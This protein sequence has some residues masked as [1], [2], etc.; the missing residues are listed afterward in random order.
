MNCQL[1]WSF[2]IVF[3]LSINFATAQ[4][5]HVPT[6]Y[7]LKTTTDFDRY[8]ADFLK[9]VD[10]L[11]TN[12]PNAKNRMQANAFTMAYLEG[13]PKF[14]VEIRSYITTL[15]DANPELILVFLGNWGKFALQNPN[16]SKDF[17][18]CGMAGLNATLAYYQEFK[19]LKPD[20]DLDKLLKLQ[21]G[22]RLGK[23]LEKQM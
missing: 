19:S 18:A 20:K 10:W 1:L 15:T 2:F 11:T 13:V 16:Q 23:W 7:Q 21:E 5:F 17:H 9:T 22:G 6:N 14:T 3:S 4:D 12:A 8:E